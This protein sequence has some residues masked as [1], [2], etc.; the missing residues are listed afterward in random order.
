MVD[1]C[2]RSNFFSAHDPYQT[3]RSEG[4]LLFYHSR[5]L[6]SSGH[7]FR[8]TYILRSSDFL[9]TTT[10]DG[11]TNHFTPYACMQGN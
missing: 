9:W 1:R 3:I 5:H 4:S 6:D 11:Q 8:Y 7:S 10:I 2:D